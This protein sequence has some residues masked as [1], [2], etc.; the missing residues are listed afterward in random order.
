MAGIHQRVVGLVGVMS[1]GV[2][3]FASL[4]DGIGCEIEAYLGQSGTGY[5]IN[6]IVVHDSIAYVAADDD[7]LLIYDASDPG[8][9]V[10]MSQLDTPGDAKALDVGTHDGIIRVYIADGSGGLLVVNADDPVTPFFPLFSGIDL[11]DARDVAVHA[12]SGDGEIRVSVAAGPEGYRAYD[13]SGLFPAMVE[14][15]FGTVQATH[16][17]VNTVGVDEFIFVGGGSDIDVYVEGNSTT[18]NQLATIDAPLSVR[19]LG[20]KGDALYVSQSGNG[21]DVYELSSDRTSAFLE[22]N[23]TLPGSANELWID[24]DRLFVSSG[25]D[26]LYL[27]EIAS[28]LSPGYLS[29][30]RVGGFVVGAG[31]SGD[32]MF[33]A[34]D[35]HG[36]YGVD[37]S[38]PFR[39]ISDALL[40]TYDW[41]DADIYNPQRTAIVS[42]VAFVPRDELYLFDVTTDTPALLGE[43][44]A[45]S[46]VLAVDA[47]GDLACVVY[48]GGLDC[49]DISD[50]SAPVLDETLALGS[51]R[52]VRLFE[53]AGVV[54]ALVAD[55]TNGMRIVDLS[56]PGMPTIV[57]T[58]APGASVDRIA[59]I[60]T[61]AFGETA[62]VIEDD[63]VALVSLLSL[64]TPAALST[65][66]SGRWIRAIELDGNTMYVGT[67][68]D[69]DYGHI[70]VVDITQPLLPMLVDT[71]DVYASNG[72]F[73]AFDLAIDGD[74]LHVAGDASGL[75]AM[76]VSAGSVPVYEGSSGVLSGVLSSALDG[77]R[78]LVRTGGMLHI[79]DL[80]GCESS[81]PADLN[82]DGMLN[83]FDVSAFLSAFNTQDPIAD[84]SGD[85]QFNFFDVSAFLQAYNAGCP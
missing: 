62:F 67:T 46:D 81:C 54:Y 52:D 11:I 76:D 80:S 12:P 43:Y 73:G 74:R 4:G 69:V 27:A 2:C 47:L 55:G 30:L 50:P 38:E 75:F 45:G 79:V 82:D 16:V 9:L 26:D 53:R 41:G 22:D 34:T 60:G 36:I 85:G 61:T 10:L 66:G 48:S 20:V 6:D 5:E 31:A 13:Y 72:S 33:V 39:F 63:Q 3:S 51:A 44:D 21:V 8:A 70:E 14:L 83:F 65:Y 42:G 71:V 15:E 77:D 23:L 25:G 19:G 35:E 78:A 58:Y 18:S 17:A 84:F 49:L 57:G 59:M 37:I 32:T 29:T 40:G 68:S 1:L 56:D 24:G 7:G 64:T 28:P